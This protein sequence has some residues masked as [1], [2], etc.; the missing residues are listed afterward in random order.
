MKTKECCWIELSEL[1]AS[2]I[3]DFCE[4][5]A[6]LGCPRSAEP[7]MWYRNLSPKNRVAIGEKLIDIIERDSER[8]ANEKSG[9]K[10]NKGAKK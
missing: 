7:D 1:V 3:L 4:N 2:V 6:E 10:K 8:F 9:K 5:L